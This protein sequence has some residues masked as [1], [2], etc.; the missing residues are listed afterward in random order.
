MG[1]KEPIAGMITVAPD[2]VET[3]ARLT[4]LAVPGVAR[5]I[6]PT[7]LKRLLK[8]D[9]V[10]LEITG[11][12]VRLDLYVVTDPGA[13]MLTIGRKIQAEVTRAIE[14]MVGMEVEA[15]NIHIEDVAYRSK[16][17]QTAKPKPKAQAKTQ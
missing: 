7:G 4:A 3:I 14:E 12:T 5:L 1:E 9:G 6:S 16:S 17:K 8:Q 10:H 11:N 15:V 13:S 2:V